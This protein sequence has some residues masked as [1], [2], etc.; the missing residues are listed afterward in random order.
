M[1]L[2]RYGVQLLTRIPIRRDLMLHA[3]FVRQAVGQR[4]GFRQAVTRM[5]QAGV[6]RPA[7]RPGGQDG[8]GR[9]AASALAGRPGNAT[10][11]PRQAA[12]RSAAA[13]T[14]SAPNCLTE[15]SLS[16]TRPR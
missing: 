10:V 3:N 2:E 6:Q 12:A 15:M 5:G 1:T 7:V 9:G 11:L 14:C 13:R 16:A 4:S 8:C